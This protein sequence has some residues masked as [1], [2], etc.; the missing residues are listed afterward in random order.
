MKRFQVIWPTL[1]LM[2]SGMAVAEDQ[3]EGLF[4]YEL[5]GA[6]VTFT[7]VPWTFAVSS[8]SAGR[9]KLAGL[10]ATAGY[11]D[12]T[13]G[14]LRRWWLAELRDASD[15]PPIQG[16]AGVITTLLNLD[17]RA[18]FYFTPEF[19]QANG[20]IFYIAPGV[21]AKF[22]DGVDE[23]RVDEVVAAAGVPVA[24]KRPYWAAG[25]T[26]G[27][28]TRHRSAL[29]V[30][31]SAHRLALFPEVVYAYPDIFNSGGVVSVGGGPREEDIP[32]L[33][34]SSLEFLGLA[35]AVAAMAAL[36]RRRTL[37]RR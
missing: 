30:L 34:P 17:R 5:S 32:T 25:N 21:I 31:D 35:V 28:V 27:F 23:Q 18:Q 6:R 11:P 8:D 22:E 36:R 26:Y 19:K 14:S 2:A 13:I 9:A 37:V 15:P 10:L 4:Y 24:L 7:P 29:E 16:V 1:L 12:A 33:S 20:N 3:D